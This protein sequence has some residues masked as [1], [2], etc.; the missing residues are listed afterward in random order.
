MSAPTITEAQRNELRRRAAR[1]HATDVWVVSIHPAHLLDLL[2]CAD[3]VSELEE[4]IDLLFHFVPAWAQEVPD[5]LCPTMYGT[6]T[7]EGDRR[8]KGKVDELRA[9]LKS[10]KGETFAES[11]DAED[12][13]NAHDAIL[14]QLK[15]TADD[16]DAAL[17]KVKELEEG[18]ERLRDSF[19]IHPRG[20]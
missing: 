3:R 9:L 20:L 14:A 15:T 12:W 11:P 13:K 5:G 8:V 2:D 16:R 4:G 6:G 19:D 7:A 10:G 1:A 18:M 17:V